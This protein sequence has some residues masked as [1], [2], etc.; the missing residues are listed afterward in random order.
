[1][2][3]ELRKTVNTPEPKSGLKKILGCSLIAVCLLSMST[4]GLILSDSPLFAGRESG[5]R[6]ARTKFFSQTNPLPDG[7]VVGASALFVVGGVAGMTG[8]YILLTL[9]KAAPGRG[10]HARIRR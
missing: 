9:T 10:R 8:L 7:Y 6:T 1:L 3:H 2:N 4:A 5:E